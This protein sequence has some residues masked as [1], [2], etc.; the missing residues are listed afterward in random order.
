[1]LTEYSL[2]LGL[3]CLLW[4]AIFAIA[5][6]FR[7]REIVY[8]KRARWTMATLRGIS[9]ALI[10]FLLLAPMLRQNVKETEKPLLIFAI[11]NSQSMALTQDSLFY[12]QTLP[13][14]LQQF[15]NNFGD[16][17]QVKTYLMGEENRLVADNQALNLTFRDETSQLS[18]LF[19][20]ID[21]LY[22]SHNI[23]A[24]VWVSD[25]IYNTGR[26]P[27]Y[28]TQN[29]K[30]PIYTVGT[31]DT[32]APIDLK[33]VESIHNKQ[34][35]LG[36]FFPVEIK[37]NATH[38]AGRS[39]Q[40]TLYHKGEV[41]YE[42]PINIQGNQHFETIKLV[43]EAQEKGL[44]KYRIALTEL[45]DEITYQNNTQDFF[46]QVVDTRE[47]IA[48]VYAAPHPDVSS[49]KQALERYEKYDIETFAH[50]KFNKEVGD[51]SLIIFHQL[52]SQ[53]K[54]AGK[55]LAD[56]QTLK[57]PAW[58]I[59]GEESDIQSFNQLSH[60]ITITPTY[61]GNQLM[62]NEV[63]P[64][65]NENFLLF[66][67]SEEV[68]QM[69]KYY[70]PLNT[71][72][73]NYQLSGNAST[74]LYQKINRV[75]TNY[76]LISFC[77]AN[78]QRMGVTVGTGIWNWRL[79]N[80]THSQNFD[81]FDEMINKIVLYLSAKGD[82]SRFRIHCQEL[83]AENMPIEIGAEVY[84][85]SY[86]LIN[87]PDVHFCLTDS[88]GKEYPSLFSKRNNSYYLHLGKLAAGDYRWT[89]QTDVGGTAYNRSGEFSVE[90]V[91][92]E[93][94]QLTANHDLLR[95]MAEQSK[96]AFFKVGEWEALE[97][98]IKG[99]EKIK[100]VVSYTQRYAPLLDSWIYFVL[101]ILLLG[102]EWFM[103]KWGGGY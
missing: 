14:Q 24:M 13:T 63:T 40:L 100:S 75:I 20:E 45:P 84:T 30:Y 25:G 66:T 21:A 1:M 101:I 98:A 18:T 41:I 81:A 93:S 54:L 15:I 70:S 28:V 68:Q 3:L 8:S 47:K 19:S 65:L 34:T 2:W 82:K 96:G 55:L 36:N 97:E 37:I 59:L 85:E 22:A 73:G 48:I 103:R 44:Q 89:A 46:I 74:F 17:Y 79:Q 52:P 4:G 38:L 77:D 72:F 29:L 33:I 88:Q 11:D 83:Y 67:L 78:S 80:Y 5:L 102:I 86:E 6:Y 7:Y 90:E 16:N 58:F 51:Y 62:M 57:I 39:A 10:A 35:F 23:G 69:L 87:S 31:G 61:N 26:D 49:L 92:V 64:T 99:N 32:T 27:Q 9:I 94:L 50:D 43:L 91:N 12:Q 95:T 42:Q 71:F 56:V 76:P 53:K 60:G